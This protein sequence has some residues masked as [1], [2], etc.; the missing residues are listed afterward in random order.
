MVGS[1][2]FGQ[3]SFA[4]IS[5]LNLCAF[6]CLSGVSTDLI[7]DAGLNVVETVERFKRNSPKKV[8]QVS[9]GGLLG[10]KSVAADDFLIAQLLFPDSDLFAALRVKFKRS[11]PPLLSYIVIYLIRNKAPSQQWVDSA[12]S[13]IVANVTAEKS[14]FANWNASLEEKINELEP[15]ARHGKVFVGRKPDSFGP[16]ATAIRKHLKKF[17]DDKPRQIWQA[18]VKRSPKGMRFVEAP[19]V[20]KYVEYVG[21]TTADDTDYKHFQNRVAEQRKRL[22]ENA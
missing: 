5:T 21:K 22:K 15:A 1:F 7:T 14:V 16:L 2:D 19:H 9:G 13:Y 12:L 17:P 18:F 3:A 11:A 10:P 6:G 8:P 20:G 4:T